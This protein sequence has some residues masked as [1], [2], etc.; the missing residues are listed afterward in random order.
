LIYRSINYMFCS[1]SKE[2]V[3]TENYME[4]IYVK[5]ARRV[6]KSQIMLTIRMILDCAWLS[7]IDTRKRCSMDFQDQ[8]RGASDF[9]TIY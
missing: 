4:P 6:N 5:G 7:L 3:I 9:Q 8:L 2:T 1:H